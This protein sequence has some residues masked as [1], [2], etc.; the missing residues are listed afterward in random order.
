MVNNVYTNEPRMEIYD[1]QGLAIAFVRS[2]WGRPIVL[3]HNGGM[4]HAIWRDVI[5]LLEHDHEVFA[6]DLLGFGASARP[7]TGYTLDH[8]VAIV[9]G[10]LDA[11]GLTP[12][13]LVGNCM[14][15]AISLTLAARRPDAAS[16]LV[17]INPLTEATFR[18]GGLG[19]TLALTR[20]LPTLSRPVVG[21]LR[22]THLPRAIARQ[23][24]RLQLGDLGRSDQLERDAELCACHGAP[25]N[26][27]SLLGV[28]DDLAAYRALDEFTPSRQFPPITTIWGLD[29][30]VL[31]ADVGRSLASRWRAARSEWLLGCGHLPMLEEPERVAKIIADAVAQPRRMASV[32]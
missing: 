8:H 20:A 4:S 27:R 2:G 23:M 21:A 1:H 29:N 15:S 9:G 31:S 19:T 12:A 11:L 3:L 28:F 22:R 13:A 16:A 24:V 14:G 10:F 30:R 7:G 6:L 25:G 32:S 17:L 26:M 18:A 5:P